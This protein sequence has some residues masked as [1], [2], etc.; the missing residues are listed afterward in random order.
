[1]SNNVGQN[2]YSPSQL[3]AW[4]SGTSDD[5]EFLQKYGSF[6]SN[7]VV[8][9]KENIAVVERLMQETNK[10]CV[11]NPIALPKR[12]NENTT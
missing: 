2:K 10:K 5:I 1:M 4:C 9:L 7:Y 6:C 3:M 11:K 12:V 8:C